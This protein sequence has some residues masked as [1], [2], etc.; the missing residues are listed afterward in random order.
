[1]GHKKV[2]RDGVQALDPRGGG[3][4]KKNVRIATGWPKKNDCRFGGGESDF[5]KK[6]QRANRLGNQIIVKRKRYNS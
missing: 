6:E 1:L 5:E 3:R 4:K 2:S